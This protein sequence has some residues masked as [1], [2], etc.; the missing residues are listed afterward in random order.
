M[1]LRAIVNGTK[2]F[3][4]FGDTLQLAED[5]CIIKLKASRTICIWAIK[6]CTAI[7]SELDI[8]SFQGIGVNFGIMYRAKVF[9]P[10]LLACLLLV[11]YTS[12]KEGFWRK[13]RRP[14]H[15]L[16]H[17]DRLKKITAGGDENLDREKRDTFEYKPPKQ[18]FH[19]YYY[20]NFN[21]APSS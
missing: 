21:M 5:E 13:R 14:I 12:C 16:T 19:N 11:N 20:R 17:P 3:D 1:Y 10:I 4:N 15:G 9:L 2:Y 6:Q 8:K 18:T 7:L